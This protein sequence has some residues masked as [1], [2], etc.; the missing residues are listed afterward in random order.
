[1]RVTDRTDTTAPD[2]TADVAIIGG[3]CAG[4][5]TAVRLAATRPDLDVVLLEG[6]SSADPRSWCS[7]DDGSDPVPEA[8]SASWD[9]WEVRTDRGTAIGSDPHHPYVLVRAAD[10]W[11]AVERRTRGAVRLVRGAVVSRV[12][13]S[14][15]TSTVHAGAD[16]VRS[17]SVLDATGPRC[18]EHVAPGRVLLHQRFVG[19]WIET[20]RPVFDTSTVTLMDFADGDDARRARH[21]RFVYV[22]PVTSTR[23][24]VE[25][26]L[27][28]ADAADPFDHRAAIRAYVGD[29]W[30]LA[31]DAWE[32]T[33]EEAGCIPM[34]DAPAGDL[35]GR[36]A[37]PA[38][39][40]G[41]GG[42]GGPGVAPT[43]DAVAG[44]TRP[45]SGYGF[46]RTNRH[47][48]T[49]AR[50]L[51]DG[52]PVPPHRDRARTRFLDAVFLRFLRD[53]PGDAPEVF[54]RLVAMPGPLVVRFLT[55]RST[56]LD[57]LRIV[58]ALPKPPFLAA[59][60]ATVLER[61]PRRDA[62]R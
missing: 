41:A 42:R 57:D 27:F 3:G 7:W 36:L 24:L 19:Q 11:A 33:E 18:P 53:R 37:R 31:D 29:R 1:M 59:L 51:A 4:L 45:S 48:E 6:R 21:V 40:P 46:A 43:L 12:D 15:T 5:A 55:E 2:V 16:T 61:R 20:D 58:L 62:R 44:T 17:R 32:V 52:T 13:R 10:R 8:R 39:R 60:A 30:Q 22:L 25:S 28:T 35:V 23:A 56:P 9:R 26:T 34:T 47:S 38:D 50:H 54:R 49:V 14:G